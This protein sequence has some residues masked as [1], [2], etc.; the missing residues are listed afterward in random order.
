MHFHGPESV[1]GLTLKNK[2]N[3]RLTTITKFE[4]A[5]NGINLFSDADGRYYSSNDLQEHW[6]KMEEEE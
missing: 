1:I 2:H 3:E 4:I 6:I 5:D